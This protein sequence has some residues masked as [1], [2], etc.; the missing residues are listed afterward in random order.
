MD[1]SQD[2]YLDRSHADDL[3]NAAFLDDFLQIIDEQEAD[4][5]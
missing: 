2:S 5:G 1:K 3:I 4:N